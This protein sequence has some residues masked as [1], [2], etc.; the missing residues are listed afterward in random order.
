VKDLIPKIVEVVDDDF[1]MQEPVARNLYVDPGKL[2]LTM[3][4]KKGLNAVY[5]F[6]GYNVGIAHLITNIIRN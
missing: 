4:S 2:P 1:Y 6:S 3:V 5:A